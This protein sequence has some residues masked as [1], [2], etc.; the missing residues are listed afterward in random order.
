M[1][2]TTRL[3]DLVSG[4][5][6]QEFKAAKFVVRVAFSSDGKYLAVASYDHSVRVYEATN[7]DIEEVEVIDDTDDAALAADPG[8]RYELLHTAKTEANP[9]A[10]LFHPRTEWLL[11]TVRASHEL[12]YLRLPT[13]AAAS[14]AQDTETWKVV[15]K[16]FNPHPLDVHVSFAV[17]DLALHPSGRALACITG[18]HAGTAGER[19]LVYGVEPDEVSRLS[20]EPEFADARQHAS[21]VFGP[22]RIRTPSSFPVSRGCR[23]GAGSSRP[24]R[25]ATLPSSAPPARCAPGYRCT[26]R[27]G[28]VR[29][30]SCAIWWS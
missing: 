19:V 27:R 5:V 2:G 12:H 8:M 14:V 10:L 16:S 22:E 7:A 30:M 3:I 1:D 25:P 29:A 20:L 15:T 4:D 24:A 23:A 28:R 26:R 17:L 9:E 6:L 18:D 21:R 11:Y 13:P